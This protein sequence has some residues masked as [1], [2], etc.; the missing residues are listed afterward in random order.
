MGSAP[1]SESSGGLSG[2]SAPRAGSTVGRSPKLPATCGLGVDIM[3]A[4]TVGTLPTCLRWSAVCA[5]AGV[6]LAGGCQDPAYKATQAV[7]YQRIRHL[8]ASHD[9]REAE[10]PARLAALAKLVEDRK[11]A[12]VEQ[13]DTTIRRCKETRVQDR[14]DWRAQA[15]LR[16][17]RCRSNLAGKPARIPDVWRS[18]TY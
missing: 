7:R 14:R 18:M 10:R 1:V 2:V 4:M 15:P 9:A 12:R 5:L 11:G 3:M 6:C 13:L 16:R 17:E 8:Q